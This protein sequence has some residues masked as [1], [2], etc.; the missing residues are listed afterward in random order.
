MRFCRLEFTHHL[1]VPAGTYPAGDADVLL[2]DVVDAPAARLGRR[3]GPD[4]APVPLQTATLLRD[5]D[6]LAGGAAGEAERAA[7]QAAALAHLNVAIR[8]A[9]CA[10]GDPYALE[11]TAAD[12]RSVRFGT[13]AFEEVRDGLVLGEAAPAARPPRR[14]RGAERTEQVRISQEVA[15][16]L[17]GVVGPLEGEE[18]ALRVLLDL[19][20]GR[21]RAA[22]GGARLAV[23]VLRE[24]LGDARRA[25][26]TTELD[27][28][29]VEAIA[30]HVLAA[31]RAHRAQL[32][33]AD[34]AARD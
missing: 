18:L 28:G 33:E 24:E 5:G 6:V 30:R 13:A 22:R 14:I 3:R 11:V 2:L 34:R 17:R 31:A 10:V 9:R 12:A 1:G 25:P 26:P 27:A 8:A 16:A 21:L 29:E 19:E 15:G 7:L 4:P 23:E 32:L 20:H